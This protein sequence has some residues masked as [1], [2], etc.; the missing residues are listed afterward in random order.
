LSQAEKIEPLA[1]AFIT[2]VSVA[3]VPEELLADSP[4][5]DTTQNLTHLRS[6]LV[7]WVGTCHHM[8]D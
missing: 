3:F 7:D 6:R 8:M 1:N 2:S 5:C 4:L